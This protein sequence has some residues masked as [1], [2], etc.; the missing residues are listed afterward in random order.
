MKIEENLREKIKKEL[1]NKYKENGFDYTEKSL[2]GMIVDDFVYDAIDD[3]NSDSSL[4]DIC[5]DITGFYDGS[6]TC[7]TYKSAQLIGENIFEFNDIVQ[8]RKA[9]F[10]TDLKVTDTEW[11]LVCVL[12][13]ICDLTI[14]SCDCETL[15]ELVEKLS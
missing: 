9:N 12:L 2:C 1:M 5:S 8:E 14:L 10:G 11:N 7:N 4:V 3:Y 13:Y 15:G 6:Y